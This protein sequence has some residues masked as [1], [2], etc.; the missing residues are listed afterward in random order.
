MKILITGGAG[1]I[2]SHLV[3]AL[4]TQNHHIMVIDSLIDGHLSN[5]QSHIDSG[6]C[7]FIQAD[8]R[9]RKIMLEELP[10]VDM[11]F[12]FA[13]DPDVRNSV[14]NPMSSYDH[15]MNGTMMILEYMRAHNIKKML[16]ASSGGTIYGEVD[17]YPIFEKTQFHPISPYGA[18][19]AGAEMYLSAYAHSYGFKIASVRFANIFGE[20]SRHGVGWDFY[21]H[22]KE[23]PYELT[24]LGDGTQQKSYM[25]V[26]DAIQAVLLVSEQI[27]N[28]KKPYDAFNVGSESWYTV[29]EIAQI[30]E[31]EMGLE[32]VN[33]QYTGGSRGWV[34]DVAKMLLSIDKLKGLG[35]K[36][37]V[38]FT[39]G[40][41]R[42]VNWMENLT[43]S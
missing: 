12:H 23:N 25:H 1:F 16:F 26:S 39:E 35:F 6:I 37:Q 22:L 42:Y 2:G 5:I 28:Q 11:I 14:P 4:V 15:N 19:K 3:D 38:T 10:K 17:E 36:E 33:H 9:D 27:E 30:Y 32:N 24:I 13:A 31:R 43:H 40:V 18:S 7:E 34:G 41:H 8:I 21:H 29:D 20:R